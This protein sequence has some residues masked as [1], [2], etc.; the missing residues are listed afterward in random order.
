MRIAQR[1]VS[2]VNPSSQYTLDRWYVTQYGAVGN[3]TVSQIQSGLANFSNAFQLATTS[4]SS[5]N[6]MISQ[7]LETR[8]IVRFQGQAVTVSFWYR[9]PTSFTNT[10]GPV[11]YWTTSVDTAISNG[12]VGS[13]NTA[14]YGNMTNTTVW[15]YV[16]Y[17][18]FVPSTAQAL[19][20]MFNNYNNVVN[21]ATIQI[22]G[23]QLEKGS[24][25]TPFE[26]RPFATELALCQRYYEQSY[27]IGTAPGTNSANGALFVYGSSDAGSSLQFTQRYIVPK[28][29]AVS[30]TFY[31]VSTGVTGQWDYAR[32]GASGA[33][34][35]TTYS[36]TVYSWT[37]TM[38][39]G[40]AFVSVNAY[41]NWV[42]NAEL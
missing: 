12:I 42:A 1:G 35:I 2:F 34:S 8:D 15:T 6:W 40:S 4:T 36:S 30:P 24:V 33:L 18:A 3:G 29:V 9:I 22:T 28:R 5:G 14:G 19:S 20:V 16:Q 26:V 38:A 21:G 23:V 25:A 32:S 41:G 7:S 13:P 31:R 11:L 27:E 17:Q 10:W 37:G 39:V